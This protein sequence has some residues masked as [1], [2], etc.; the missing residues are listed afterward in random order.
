MI[1]I[2]VPGYTTT[3]P[4]CR[5]PLTYHIV[6]QGTNTVCAF[7]SVNLV[8]GNI[9]ISGLTLAQIHLTHPKEF[10]I[11]FEDGHVSPR[12]P[13][14]LIVSHVCDYTSIQDPGLAP[15]LT[16]V[17]LGTPVPSVASIWTDIEI[18]KAT[19]NLYCGPRLITITSASPVPLFLTATGNADGTNSFSLMTDDALHVDTYTVTMDVTLPNHPLVAAMSIT[20]EVTI[21]PCVLTSIT[22]ATPFPPGP[23]AYVI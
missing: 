14:D 19:T 11:T 20:M 1:T 8:S 3:P 10:Y 13:F 2:P 9:E 17:K 22:I 23:H 6:D 16:T 5:L 18:T 12:V 15:M 7:S 21:D 4:D